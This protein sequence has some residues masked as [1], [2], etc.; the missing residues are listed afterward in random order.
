ML[1]NCSLYVVELRVGFFI[2]LFPYGRSI[3]YI[4]AIA[5]AKHAKVRNEDGV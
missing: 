4:L 3:Q 1:V 2:D 5:Q